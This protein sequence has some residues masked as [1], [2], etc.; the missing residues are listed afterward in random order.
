MEKY[1]KLKKYMDKKG[2]K[3]KE[4]K[5]KTKSFDKMKA[6]EKWDIFEEMARDLGYI[7]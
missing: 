3:K 6:S 5:I 7:E 4:K 1:K 2:I